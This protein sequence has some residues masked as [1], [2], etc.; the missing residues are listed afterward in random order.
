MKNKQFINN[1]SH[2]VCTSP[3]SGYRFGSLYRQQAYLNKKNKKKKTS[4]M[5]STTKENKPERE[6]KRTNSNKQKN[7]DVRYRH[8]FSLTLSGNK[9]V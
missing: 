5:S 4:G 3:G 8:F 7:L 9:D 2:R 1:V 6:G